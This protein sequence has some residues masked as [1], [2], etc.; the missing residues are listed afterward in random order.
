MLYLYKAFTDIN[1]FIYICKWIHFRIKIFDPKWLYKHNCPP[2]SDSESISRFGSPTHPSRSQTS[3]SISMV[4]KYCNHFELL[5]FQ[6][7]LSRRSVMT[8]FCLEVY[9]KEFYSYAKII[10]KFSTLTKRVHFRKYSF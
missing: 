7:L 8:W 5:V 10:Q 2:P 1:G 4:M 9:L 6:G 3:P